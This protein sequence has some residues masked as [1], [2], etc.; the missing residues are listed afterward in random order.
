VHPPRIASVYSQMS[1]TL[2]SAFGRRLA[3]VREAYGQT[4]GQ[5]GINQQ[6]FASALGIEAE[7][8]RKY[9]RGEREPPFEVLARIKTLTGFGPDFLILGSPP[10]RAA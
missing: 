3:V 1:D 9:E 7:R 5:P 6:E 8:Y 2:R 10:S 4:T